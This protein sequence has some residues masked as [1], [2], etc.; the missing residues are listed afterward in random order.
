M[1]PDAWFSSATFRLTYTRKH[2]ERFFD[3]VRRNL[4][5]GFTPNA[6]TPDSNWPTCLK[7]AA[8]DRAR[9]KTTPPTSRSDICRQCFQQY[10]YD[11]QNPPSRSVLPGRQEVF[12]D[13]DPQGLTAVTGFL[14][15][16][17]FNLIG[18]LVGLVVA[19]GLAIGGL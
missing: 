10:C 2:T 15:K 7:C 3:Q 6:N 19:I 9:F 11:P 18:G 16:N 17:K 5:S 13:P 14:G 4:F 1:S 12:V 8:I